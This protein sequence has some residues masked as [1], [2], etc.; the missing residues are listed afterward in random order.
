[1]MSERRGDWEDYRAPHGLLMA[2]VM[3]AVVAGPLFVLDGGDAVRE[4]MAELLGPVGLPLLPLGL[5][6]LIRVLSSGLRLADVFGFAVGDS[7]DAV[8]RSGR[9][10]PV[11]VVLALLLFLL[12]VYYRSWS[13]FGGGDDE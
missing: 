5:V 10:S 4:A 8:Y 2:V 7:L 9:G 11:G 13:P 1:M 12:A 6:L 3:G